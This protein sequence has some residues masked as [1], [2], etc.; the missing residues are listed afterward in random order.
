MAQPHPAQTHLE[1]TQIY[2]NYSQ[3]PLF[4]K[5]PQTTTSTAPKELPCFT[6]QGWFCFA[7]GGFQTIPT[8]GAAPQGGFSPQSPF[9]D[10]KEHQEIPLCKNKTSEICMRKQSSLWKSLSWMGAGGQ[11]YIVQLLTLPW[12]LMTIFWMLISIIYGIRMKINTTIY[13]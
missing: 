4:W 9:G 7:Q 5:E 8:S 11:G 6:A 12:K 1:Q 13:S 2:T 3:K 10:C